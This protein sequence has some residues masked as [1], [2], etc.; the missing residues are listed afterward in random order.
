MNVSTPSANKVQQHTGCRGSGSGMQ[1]FPFPPTTVASAFPQHQL[2]IFV[3]VP[4]QW[5]SPGEVHEHEPRPGVAADAVVLCT[6][7]GLVCDDS[8]PHSS[9]NLWSSEDPWAGC[10]RCEQVMFK[11]DDTPMQLKFRSLQISDCC[12]P[13]LA[14]SPW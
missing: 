13:H 2:H 10:G 8:F 14:D 6:L 12:P 9:R 7:L 5:L 11:S 1:G 4:F 3:S